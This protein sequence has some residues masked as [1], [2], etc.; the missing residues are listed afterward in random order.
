MP[1]VAFIIWTP[2]YLLAPLVCAIFVALSCYLNQCSAFM[3]RPSDLAPAYPGEVATPDEASV[4]SLLNRATRIQL[5]DLVQAVACA[6]RAHVEA[7]ALNDQPLLTHSKYVLGSLL[8]FSGTDY[9]RASQLLHQALESVERA[10]VLHK[11]VLIQLAQ[12]YLELDDLPQ[13]RSHLLN[14]LN[15]SSLDDDAHGHATILLSL[16]RAADWEA[17][18]C[19]YLDS[20]LLIFSGI[21]DQRGIALTLLEYGSLLLRTGRAIEAS[22]TLSSAV[23]TFSSLG[24][25][26]SRGVALQ[27][28]AEAL[29]IRGLLPQALSAIQSAI[30][31]TERTR[32]AS[33]RV[34]VLRIYA[35]IATEL[36]DFKYAAELQ[37]EA[38][39]LK[40]V[41]AYG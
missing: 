1:V 28:L 4:R 9:V 8:R 34:D 10:S 15:Y 5:T 41:I 36:E 21:H 11:K 33:L 29:C 20:A 2:F 35:R 37:E 38:E 40:A 25:E 16:G 12:L 13:A 6:E 30:E 26:R 19:A 14:A 7:S 39:A 3:L 23:R 31:I 17:S 18:R 32:V 27:K 24:D 22:D